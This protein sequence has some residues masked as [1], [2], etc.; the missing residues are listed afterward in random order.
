MTG[1]TSAIAAIYARR[2]K[3]GEITINDVPEKIRNDIKALLVI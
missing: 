2:I 1:E 3:R